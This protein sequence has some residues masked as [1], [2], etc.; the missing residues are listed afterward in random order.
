MVAAVEITGEVAVDTAA[1]V[2]EAAVDTSLKAATKAKET[3]MVADRATAAAAEVA[4]AEVGAQE[5]NPSATR[6]T[7][8]L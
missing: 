7:L 5:A 4:T 8:S 6:R 2:T 1:G 3:V